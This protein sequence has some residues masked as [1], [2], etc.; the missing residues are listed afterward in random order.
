M[1]LS[2]ELGSHT[3]TPKNLQKCQI[4]IALV[5]ECVRLRE[6]VLVTSHPSFT[7]SSALAGWAAEQADTGASV[8]DVADVME[9]MAEGVAGLKMND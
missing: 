2:V 9:L 1:R 8:G 7:S 4:P 6:R 5:S 3:E